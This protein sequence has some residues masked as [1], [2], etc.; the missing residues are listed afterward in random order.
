M[1]LFRRIEPTEPVIGMYEQSICLVAQGTKR[2]LLGYDTFCTNRL[3]V[4]P[5]LRDLATINCLWVRGS[6]NR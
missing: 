1:A 2:V 5:P 6:D 4:P 3:S